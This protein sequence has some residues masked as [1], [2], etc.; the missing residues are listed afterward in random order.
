M[1]SNSV[2]RLLIAL[3]ALNEQAHI[4]AVLDGLAA[5]RHDVETSS[6]LVIDDGSADETAA[7][8]LEH[9]ATVIRHSR[10]MGVGGAFH[11]AVEQALLSGADILVTIDAD[12]QFD[13]EQIGRLVAPILEGRAHFVSGTRFAGGRRP[14]NMPRGKYWGNLLVTRLLRHFTNQSL[15]DVSCGFRAYSRE[16][17]FHLNL[18]GKFTYTQETIMDLSFKGL[19]L[20]EVP[21]AVRYSAERRSRVAGSL[22]RYGVN[23]LKIIL[24]TARD[25]KPMRF[26]GALGTVVFLVGVVLD[27]WL[28][29]YFLRTGGFSPYKFVGFIGVVL[30]IAGLLVFG[31]AL[32]AD[33]LDRMR[34]NQER[35]LYHVRRQS[36]GAGSVRSE[37]DAG[38]SP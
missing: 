17:L 10:N 32:L 21:V 12:G 18:F 6:W 5:C 29:F 15:T 8:A 11:T 19:R 33:M 14:A 34:V 20:A 38:R 2:S 35:L 4:G 36:Y 23:A 16:A 22:F 9:G 1:Q 37:P 30:N 26:F 24:R 25:F 28:W 3:P 31:M 13:P 7:V 27:T